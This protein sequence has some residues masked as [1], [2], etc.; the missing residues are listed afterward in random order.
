MKDSLSAI[1]F[2][3]KGDPYRFSNMDE[4][5]SFLDTV[6]YRSEIE[7][8]QAPLL[9]QLLN[10]V[11]APLANWREII[12]EVEAE[13]ERAVN[14]PEEHFRRIESFEFRG[15]LLQIFKAVMDIVAN[16]L[17]GEDREKFYAAREHHYKTFLIQESV[18][19]GLICAE[20]L[21]DVTTREI[22]AGRMSPDFCIRK[23]AE[24]CVAEPHFTRD[25][26]LQGAADDVQSQPAPTVLSGISGIWQ[27]VIRYFRKYVT[28]D[29]RKR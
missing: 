9:F 19:K 8:M 11:G 29:E 22:A 1:W 23:I 4:A 5:Q 18:V 6:Q 14:K 2:H 28:T 21:F 10:D 25:E 12:K 17:A 7:W 16:G 15:S 13:F 24:H 20:T 27:R 3:Y 26:M